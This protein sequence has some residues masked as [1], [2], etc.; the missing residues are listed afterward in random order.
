M[1]AEMTITQWHV[2]V[3][4]TTNYWYA[5]FTSFSEPVNKA[6][7]RDQRLKL[8]ALPDYK[9]RITQRNRY[10]FNAEEQ[11]TQTFTGMGSDINVHDQWAVESPG[12][13]Q[14]RTKEHLG[15]SDVGIA[16]YRRMLLDAIQA[17]E[18][19]GEPLMRLTPGDAARMR[20]PVTVDGIAP[21][22]TWESYWKEADQRRR[23]ASSWAAGSA[24]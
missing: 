12:A 4:D 9:P 18:R 21:T 6:Q 5:I 3:D 1:S 17:T 15:Q 10:G 22:G 16:K 13:I 14:D 7:M 19:G 23:R 2:P 20:G 11:R 24:R 8:Y